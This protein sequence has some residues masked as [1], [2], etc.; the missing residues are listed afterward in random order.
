LDDLPH[1]A[2]G[3]DRVSSSGAAD[4]GARVIFMRL[5]PYLAVAIMVA[6]DLRGRFPVR[7]I[8]TPMWSPAIWIAILVAGYACQIGMTWWAATHQMH[9]RMPYAQLPLPVVDV[10]TQYQ[11]AISAIL[12]V[13]GALQTYALLAIYRANPSRVAVAT[14]CAILALLSVAMPALASF[15]P[16][17]YVHDAILGWGAWTPP[18][19]LHGDAGLLDQWLGQPVP[20][21]YGPLWIPIVQMIT[22]ASGSLLGKLIALRIAG[23]AMFLVLLVLL[24]TLGMPRRI[25]AIAALNTGMLFEY[26][27]N[28]HNDLMPIALILVAACLVRRNAVLAAAFVMIAGIIKIP[29]AIVGL[30]ILACVPALKRYVLC[31]A[32][33]AGAV[34]V[35]WLGAG[36]AYADALFHHA[37]RA[38]SWTLWHAPV[39]VLALVLLAV[40]IAGGRRYKSAVWL[41]PALGSFSLTFTYPWYLVWGLP[42]ALGRRAVMVHLLVG[43]PLAIALVQHEFMS[44]LTFFVVYPAL[45]VL[46]C[47]RVDE[48]PAIAASAR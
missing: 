46:L 2:G 8:R 14:G 42:Y 1:L 6:C 33:I 7:R 27:A 26:V 34:W 9:E 11:N 43:F 21:F 13:L 41:F 38:A 48:R 39:V 31:V 35:T 15:D 36:K 12:I 23:L 24:R 3:R 16:Y 20:A 32:L 30:P 29:Y 28:A 4:G 44:A 19:V 5:I 40:A 37:G 22:G 18:A 45:I 10:Y 25:V 47:M 17:G